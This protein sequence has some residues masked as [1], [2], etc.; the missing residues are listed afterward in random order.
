M[1]NKHPHENGARDSIGVGYCE[2]I[3]KAYAYHHVSGHYVYAESMAKAVSRLMDRLIVLK[4]GIVEDDV[5]CLD[6][7]AI[8][9]ARA[10][11]VYC[12]VCGGNCLVRINPDSENNR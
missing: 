7:G 10:G 9:S 12:P 8:G 1:E 4:V 5:R 2:K 3:G 11:S 6:C